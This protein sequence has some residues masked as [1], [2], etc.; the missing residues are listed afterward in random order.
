MYNS[1][2]FYRLNKQ[3]DL[4]WTMSELRKPNFKKLDQRNK[5]QKMNVE[6]PHVN[7]ETTSQKWKFV[8]TKN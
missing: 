1:K 3:L 7:K 4:E 6:M 8:Q 2:I 5:K